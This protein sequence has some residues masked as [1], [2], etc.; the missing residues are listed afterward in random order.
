VSAIRVLW[1]SPE[2]PFWPGGSGGSTRQHQ[3]IVQ[4]LARGH[5][6]HV[7][8]PIHRSQ[9]AGAER[10]RAT[11]AVLHGVERPRSR[12]REV[13]DAVRARPAVALDALR[14]PL[15]AWQVEVF[16]TT[17]R[18]R[19]AALLAGAATRPDV[20]LVEH[21]WAARWVHD[22]P[23]ARGIPAVIGLENLSWGY[24]A[25]RAAAA[26]GAPARAFH[27]LE[28][29]RFA[30]FDRRHLAGYDLLLAMSHDDRRELARLT[31]TP[32]AVIP[33]GVDTTALAASPLPP[34]PV[35]LFTGTFGYP[36][37]AEGLGWLLREVW[38]RIRTGAPAAR[39]LVIGPGVP[40]PLAALAGPEVELPG[41]VERMQPWF[42][43]ARLVLVPIL[44]GAGTRLKV[45]DGLASGRPVLS[46]TMGAEGVDARDGEE[47]LI[48]DGPQ[49]FADAALRVLGDPDLAQRVGA[50]GRRLA[51]RA[52]DWRAIGAHLGELLEELATGRPAR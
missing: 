12:V 1:L 17:L 38:P 50:A 2:L 46:T 8:A 27:D 41:F 14:L 30:R 3:L 44:S 25:R 51:E 48:A 11:G 13:L 39:L 10:L 45:L 7:A 19:V 36:P 22:L 18:E 23:G 32:A 31:S 29:R 47:I 40:G 49:A 24:H 5:E 52:Y 42:D 15:T 9:R 20:I 37:N 26:T 43:R 16:W 34:D 6:V 35:V 21:D 33:N 4:L 28:A